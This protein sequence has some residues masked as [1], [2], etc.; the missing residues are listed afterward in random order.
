[1]KAGCLVCGLLAT[2]DRTRLKSGVISDCELEAMDDGTASVV[3]NHRQW[4]MKLPQ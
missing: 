1:M 3:V 2:D 4:M